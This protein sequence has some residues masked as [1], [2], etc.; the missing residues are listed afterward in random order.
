MDYYL[1]VS[2]SQEEGEIDNGSYTWLYNDKE[3]VKCTN[4]AFPLTE[5]EE[6][7]LGLIDDAFCKP[8]KSDY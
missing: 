2:Y 6:K 7:H 4:K 3:S 5:D 8:D 1:R